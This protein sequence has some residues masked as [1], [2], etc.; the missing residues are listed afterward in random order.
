MIGKFEEV[1]ELVNDTEDEHVLYGD[2]QE[3]VLVHK[4]LQN[5]H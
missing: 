5:D 1:G 3:T 2:S 4:S